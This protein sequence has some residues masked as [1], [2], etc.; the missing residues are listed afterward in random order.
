MN[1]FK[2]R[3]EIRD[4]LIRDLIEKVRKQNY[5][6]YLLSVR[7]ESIRLF[8]GARINF[9]FPVTAL[10]GPNGGG[11]STILGAVAILH[12][13]IHPKTVFR[14]SRIGD[15]SMDNWKIEYDLVDKTVNPKGT[16]RADVTFQKDTWG[17]IGISNR[18]VKVLGISR[19][20]PALENATFAFKKKLTTPERPN[21]N[22][23]I[24]TKEVEEFN[25]IK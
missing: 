17:G 12:K 7:L 1:D 11:K 15:D 23:T 9:D 8:H 5:E 4:S 16:I 6:R 20:V 25:E 21:D 22:T 13:S 14:K 2:Y 18:P 24:S 3:S 10:V 19:T